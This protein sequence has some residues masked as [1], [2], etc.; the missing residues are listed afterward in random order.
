MLDQRAHELLQTAYENGE[1]AP[2]DIAAEQWDGGD[3][4]LTEAKQAS[5]LLVTLR[6]GRY[7]DDARTRLALTNAGRYWALHGGYLGLLKEEPERA[8]TGGGRMRN[9][10]MEEVRMTYMN[11]RLKTFWWSF[12]FSVASFIMSMVSL[13]VVI[14]LRDKLPF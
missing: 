1:V 12:G 6:L 13:I 3:A 8:S 11:L 10:E 7:T 14:L 2:F 9:P 5:D 4:A